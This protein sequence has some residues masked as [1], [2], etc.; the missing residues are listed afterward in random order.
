MTRESCDI[1]I[2][3]GGIAGLVTAAALGHAG[4]SVVLVDPAPPVTDGANAQADLRS[5]AYLRPAQA[6][7]SE[8]GLW[9]QL[10]PH[11]V[12]LEALR[13]VD[14]AG[15]PPEIRD[16]RVFRSEELGEGPFGW[17]FLNWLT[18]REILAVLKRQSG[19]DLRFG[20]GFR[21]MLTRTTGAI[22]TLTDGTVIDCRLVVGADGRDSAVR[23]A[24]GIAAR[25][26]RYGQKSLAFTATHPIPHGN[27]STEI[28]HCGGPFT[29]VPLADIDGRPASAIVWMNA[30]PRSAELLGLDP[31]AFNAEMTVRSGGL[32]GP[33]ELASRR[34]IF[35]IITQRAERLTA[36]RTA[37]VAEAAHVL[38]P[39]GAQGLNTSLN[40]IAALMQAA[41]DHPG[42][43]GEPQMLAAYARARH[44]DIARRARA[45]DLFNRITRSGDV[46]LQSLRLAGLKAVHDVA[47]LR[48]KIMQAGMGPL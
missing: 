10:A 39:I 11:S 5:T 21:G 44:T 20:T 36:E 8:I 2:S 25:T 33:L 29:M 30:G 28:Y 37:L 47:P 15:D 46:G 12:P 23:E 24:A 3:G 1:L 6:L 45:I 19:I 35:P 31:A 7:F 13:I 32:F 17:N 14:M 9:D 42:A 48:R 16:E 22:V 18:R 41:R 38:P 27:V 40:D 34:G 26:T 43:L 4:F